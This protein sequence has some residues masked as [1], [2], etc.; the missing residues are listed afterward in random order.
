MR[1]LRAAGLVLVSLLACDLVDGSAPFA[2]ESAPRGSSHGSGPGS[3]GGG[4]A[5]P[6]AEFLCARSI[7]VAPM[8]LAD[9]GPPL[10]EHVGSL[11]E[12]TA[13]RGFVPSPF[14]PPRPSQD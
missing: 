11:P 3:A 1:F 4:D 12:P 5:S 7:V 9:L 6:D 10:E 14:H 2:P 8:V 13:A